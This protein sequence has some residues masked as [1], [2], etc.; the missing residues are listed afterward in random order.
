MFKIAYVD[1]NKIQ[2]SIAT[3]V[4]PE[5]SI[6]VT[7]SEDKD[8]ELSYLDEKGNLKTIVKKTSFE[9]E[10]EAN[11]WIA[12]YDYSGANINIY[13]PT[14]KSWNGYIVNAD[15]SLSKIINTENI[16]E[17]FDDMLIDGGGVPM[18]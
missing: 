4:I 8:A 14:T 11:L 3:G 6:I 18:T 5:E 1:K 10:A 17:I 16:N 15:K 9:S 2:N 7:N 12:K 13:N